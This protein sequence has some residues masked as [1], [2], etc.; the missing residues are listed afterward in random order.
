M[1]LVAVKLPLIAV[2]WFIYKVIHDVPEAE[3]SS[4]GGDFT[5]ATFDPGPRTRGPHNGGPAAAVTPRR[6]DKGH[7]DETVR[8]PSRTR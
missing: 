8:E 4:D 5:K 7:D 1:L 3:I 2:G 6:G